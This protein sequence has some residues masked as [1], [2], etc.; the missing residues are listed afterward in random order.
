[1][2]LTPWYIINSSL[3]T[4]LRKTLVVRDAILTSAVVTAKVVKDGMNT[5][6]EI[7]NGAFE[8]CLMGKF[9]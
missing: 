5:E 4:M 7:Q 8:T 2:V 1:M 9:A 3:Y 6:K